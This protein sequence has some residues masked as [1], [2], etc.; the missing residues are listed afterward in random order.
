MSFSLEAIE[1]ETHTPEYSM[2]KYWARKPHN[3]ISSFL[4]A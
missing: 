2:H 4:S 3:V 1:A